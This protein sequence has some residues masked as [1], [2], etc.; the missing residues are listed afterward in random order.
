MGETG[1]TVDRRVVG[2]TDEPGQ[3]SEQSGKSDAG[4]GE[5][6][7]RSWE[8]NGASAIRVGVVQVR[9]VKG[10]RGKEGT[11]KTKLSS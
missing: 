10:T 11:R 3:I 4:D 2:E 7:N 5:G 8:S 6:N 1:S 9:K